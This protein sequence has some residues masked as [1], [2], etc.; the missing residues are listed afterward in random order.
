MGGGRQIFQL[1]AGED[2]D[3]DDVDLGVAVLAR[4]GGGHLDDLARAVLDDDVPV[5]PQGRALHR[6]GGGGTGIGAAEVDLM[7]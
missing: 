4:L 5:L 7:L 2:V 6:E 1:L 3:G